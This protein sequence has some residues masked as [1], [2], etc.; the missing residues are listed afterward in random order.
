M[1]IFPLSEAHSNEP[2]K[3]FCFCLMVF[4]SAALWN[5]DILF[6]SE[7]LPKILGAELLIPD[8]GVEGVIGESM[9]FYIADCDVAP[10]IAS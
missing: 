6:E 5:C 1:L 8:G 10:L 7:S 3:G 4:F 9:M 2:E